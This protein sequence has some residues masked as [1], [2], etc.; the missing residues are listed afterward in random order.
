MGLTF[1]LRLRLNRGV[2][3]GKGTG[4][5]GALRDLGEGLVTTGED[6]VGFSR[7]IAFV[8]TM[9]EPL[10]STTT[11]EDKAEGTEVFEAPLCG[12]PGGRSTEGHLLD[13]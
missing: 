9:A 10:S 6:R 4:E 8:L 12:I 11:E 1:T 3:S 13:A 2:G 7:K 5:T